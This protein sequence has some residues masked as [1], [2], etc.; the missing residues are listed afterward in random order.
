MFYK[1]DLKHTIGQRQVNQ[2]DSPFGLNDDARFSSNE[3]NLSHVL[4][5]MMNVA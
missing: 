1:L 5:D 4:T 2:I 3:M